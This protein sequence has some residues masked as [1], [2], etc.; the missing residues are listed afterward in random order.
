VYDTEK[1]NSMLNKYY[2]E[3]PLWLYKRMNDY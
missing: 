3:R 1:I 2:P